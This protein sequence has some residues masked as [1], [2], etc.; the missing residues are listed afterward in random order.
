MQ[1]FHVHSY[2]LSILWGCDCEAT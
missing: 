2:S 1:D